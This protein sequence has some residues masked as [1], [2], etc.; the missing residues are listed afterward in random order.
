MTTISVVPKDIVQT[1]ICTFISIYIVSIELNVS[2]TIIAKLSDIDSNI[3]KSD[4]IVLSGA[5]YTAWGTDDNYITNYVLNYY[6]L[7]EPSS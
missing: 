5:D 4:H 1:K 6:G 7:V 2:A 3:I